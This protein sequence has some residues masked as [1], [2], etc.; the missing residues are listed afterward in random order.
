MVV[1]NIVRLLSRKLAITFGIASMLYPLI[2]V[3]HFTNFGIQITDRSAAFLFLP[4]AYMLTMLITHFWP[5][6]RL[7][8]QTVSL[9]TGIIA[10]IFMG[11]VTVGSGPNLIV[12]PGPYIVVADARSI[13]PEGTEAAMWSQAYLG[14]NKRVATSISPY[15]PF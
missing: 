11:G 13:E 7:N 10:L 1:P 8:R 9:I 14:Q 15:L 4:I 12:A 3:F 5:T 6:P 2:Q